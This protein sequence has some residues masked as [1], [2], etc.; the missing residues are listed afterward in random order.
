MPW[1]GLM[2]S[3]CLGGERGS[4]EKR[5]GTSELT[6][7]SNQSLSDFLASRIRRTFGVGFFLLIWVAGR[8][9]VAGMS[10]GL[11]LWLRQH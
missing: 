1:L 6:S 8:K 9:E 5:R 7:S 4:K 2:R 10:V 3:R 11:V